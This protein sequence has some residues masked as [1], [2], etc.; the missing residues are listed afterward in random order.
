MKSKQECTTYKALSKIIEENTKNKQNKWHLNP[1]ERAVILFIGDVLF[2][3]LSI[4]ISVFLWKLYHEWTIKNN[5]I[6]IRIGLQQLW[7]L[8]PWLIISLI[9][10][11]YSF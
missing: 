3:L 7:L 5:D 6:T 10:D 11:T 1:S 9:I 4:L 2:L 8:F